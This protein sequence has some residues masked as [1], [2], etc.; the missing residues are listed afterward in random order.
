MALLCCGRHA[1]GP[2]V[3]F[4]SGKAHCKYKVILSDQFY[5]RMKHFYPNGVV[6]SRMTMASY[7]GHKESLNGLMSMEMVLSIWLGLTGTRSKP[8]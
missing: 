8:N 1:L 2:L 5:P 7:M 3:S 6:S 4:L